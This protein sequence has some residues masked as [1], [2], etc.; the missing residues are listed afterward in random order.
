MTVTKV[1]GDQIPEEVV[2]DRLM[3]ELGAID[4][5]VQYARDEGEENLDGRMLLEVRVN[6]KGK[7]SRVAEHEKN[8]FESAIV[9]RCAGIRLKRVE[10]PWPEDYE[11]PEV[12]EGEE[13]PPMPL[14]EVTLETRKPRG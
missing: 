2:I 4:F 9:L 1:E 13:P 3:W 8:R 6:S 12:P 5:C 7:I 10:V 14:Y 11:E